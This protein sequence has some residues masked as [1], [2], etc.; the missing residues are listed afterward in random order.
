M[1]KYDI[2]TIGD[3]F[4]DIFL[5][6]EEARII[7]D[8]NFIGG[9][10]LCFGYGDKV[11][12]ENII[13]QVGGCAANTAVNFVK[14]GLGAGMISAV[15]DDSQG[16]KTVNYLEDFGVDTSMVK[17]KKE[18]NSNISVILSFKGDRTIFTY[19]GASELS[20]YIPAKNLKTRWIY[21][22]PLGEKS[23]IVE[24]RIIEI[25]AKSSAGLIWNP[26]SR[27]L[28]RPI[29]DLR[30]VLNLC[31]LL[32]VNNEEAYEL[33]DMSKRS[34]TEDVMKF[35]YSCGTKVIIVT[36]GARGAKCYDGKIFYNIGSSGDKRVEATGAGDAFASTFAAN[37]IKNS[38]D[39]KNQGFAPDRDLI[40]RSLKYGVIVSGSV[41]GSVGAQTGL[42]NFSEITERDKKLL[43]VEASV[44]T[45]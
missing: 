1:K 13:Y 10:G 28:N 7:N 19:H 20:D 37:V 32:F 18:S 33:S 26:G 11:P 8:R 27:Q 21:L 16:E 30:P 31:N 22:G 41:V 34:T 42:M 5:F 3:C 12:I 2:I 44:Y 43:K 36:D 17:R 40:E 38:P 24:N 25:I 4:E 35:I 39:S 15:G 14:L 45:K 23:E 9:E 29:K 6:P